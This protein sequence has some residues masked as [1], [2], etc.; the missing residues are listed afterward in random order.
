MKLQFTLDFTKCL[1]DGK[2]GGDVYLTYVE[3][4]NMKGR[5]YKYESYV[6]AETAR[7]AAII[8]CEDAM[9]VTLNKFKISYL[10]TEPSNEQ[11]SYL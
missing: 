5:L 10:L 9:R 1:R 11:T 3:L 7:Q 6:F 8:A 2:L 4:K